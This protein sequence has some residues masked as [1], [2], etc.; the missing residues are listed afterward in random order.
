MTGLK[1]KGIE[2]FDSARGKLFEHVVFE[3]LYNKNG[4]RAKLRCD[5]HVNGEQIDCWAVNGERI[6]VYE[7]KMRIS[8]QSVN[9]IIKQIERKLTA[10]VEMLKQI[11]LR[12][13]AGDKT[14]IKKVFGCVA[15]YEPVRPETRK[16]LEA[17]GLT[18][19]DNFDNSNN[20]GREIK[21]ILRR[22]FVP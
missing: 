1:E 5:F 10:V 2:S 12:R 22:K 14:E 19:V 21:D 15:S 3:W 11:E 16:K 9:E 7:C 8:D 18:V 17:A 20:I 13:T 6:D 4:P